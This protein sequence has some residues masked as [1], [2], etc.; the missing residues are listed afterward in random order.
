MICMETRPQNSHRIPGE[1]FAR[2]AMLVITGGSAFGY[3]KITLDTLSHDDPD[4]MYRLAE[5]GLLLTT[6]VLG[7]AAS[8]IVG[9]EAVD[10]IKKLTNSYRH[11]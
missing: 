6:F 8:Y 4:P 7:A 10:L 11:K 1:I 2:R 3:G 5:A 9:V